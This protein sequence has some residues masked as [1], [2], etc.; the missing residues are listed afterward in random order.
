MGVDALYE[1][2]FA[3]DIQSLDYP[4]AGK[5]PTLVELN[6]VLATR[7]YQVGYFIGQYICE[8]HRADTCVT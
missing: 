2:N 5:P 7:L 4:V 6:K 3:W 1:A 8:V